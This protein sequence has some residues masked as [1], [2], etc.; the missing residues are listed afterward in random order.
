MIQR[1]TVFFVVK[2][3]YVY[4]VIGNKKI[5]DCEFLQGINDNNCTTYDGTL[6]VN[7]FKNY[8]VPNIF[9]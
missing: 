3:S 1:I 8:F 2:I 9:T 4:R 5:H 7:L 6:N